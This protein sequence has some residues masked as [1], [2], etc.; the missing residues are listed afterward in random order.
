MT[1]IHVLGPS[2]V[3]VRAQ[4]S[5]LLGSDDFK[6]SERLKAFLS[7]V[8]EETLAGNEKNIKA[9]TIALGAF[10]RSPE[11][12]PQLD[13]IVRIEAG[14]LRKALEI[15]FYAHPEDDVQIIIPKGSYVPSFSY[16][17][18][19]NQ[20][21]E[22]SQDAVAEF[23]KLQEV[24]VPI[25]QDCTLEREKRPVLMLIPFSMRSNDEELGPFLSGLMDNLF[26]QI[27]NNE[28]VH[29][30]EAQTA[31][32]SSINQMNIMQFA[33]EESVRFVLHG[34]AQITGTSLR[35]YVALTD[36]DKG[37]RIWT[38]KYDYPFN[39]DSYLSVQD[40]ISRSIFSTVLDSV[41]IVART[42]VQEICYL[43]PDELGVYESTLLYV[44]WVTS[45][46]RGI[47]DK[48]RQALEQ[49]IL[50][51]PYNPILLSQISDIYS[52]D[53]QFAFNQIDNNLEKA[54]EFAKRA[55]LL[56]PSC[57][58]AQLA[59][60]LY[61]YLSRDKEQLE[62]LLANLPEQNEAN[63]YAQASVGLFFGMSCDLKEGKEMI[64]RAVAL[65]PF[66]PSCYN[67]VPF[68]YHFARGEYEE[69]LRYA[70]LINAPFCVWDPMIV[71][72]AYAKAGHT[73][74]AQIALE[75]LLKLEPN[76]SAKKNQL[77]YGLLFDTKKVEL[78]DS[79]LKE[80]GL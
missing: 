22:I 30:R 56:D 77:M 14:K 41:G 6:A 19:K 33:K 13:P 60:A 1:A 63:P 50:K 44:N 25:L 58:M 45:F 74:K 17:S 70:L 18:S 59:K 78:I 48:A 69:A 75:R 51:D 3:K 71:I 68:M 76:F 24:A 42:M 16:S 66:Q 7:F 27:Q 37:F 11:F 4:L 54:L 35:L 47:Y 73:A 43:S 34:Q 15:Y 2:P 5:R 28:V 20:Q 80:V 26:A 12:D 40:Q 55:L 8:V 38:E 61:F 32:I 79:A 52:S 10:G 67:V 46:D 64:E 21:E 57:H 31:N 36:A 65:N 29:V 72:A 62:R 49:N 39:Q 9:Y 53:Y 23:G